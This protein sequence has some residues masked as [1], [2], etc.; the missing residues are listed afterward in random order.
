[1]QA[2]RLREIPWV[3]KSAKKFTKWLKTD[4]PDRREWSSMDRRD[5]YCYRW[6]VGWITYEDLFTDLWS[7]RWFQDGIKSFGFASIEN[8]SPSWIAPLRPD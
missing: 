8:V 7:E 4:S 5:R 3:V 2:V 1:M 6:T